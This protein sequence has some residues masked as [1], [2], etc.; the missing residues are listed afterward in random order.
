MVDKAIIA[1]DV[2]IGNDVTLGYGEE[3]P[4][5]QKPSIYAFGIATV[6]ERSVIPDHVKIGKNT[7]I[8]GV[9]VPEDYPGGILAGGQN[10]A[11]KD[12]DQ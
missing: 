11:A 9:T 7:S 3:V 12:G 2:T 8:S 5:V 6:G 1:E 10:I 4:N